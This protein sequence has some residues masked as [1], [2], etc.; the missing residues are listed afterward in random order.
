VVKRHLLAFACLIV[1]L[2][3]A[4]A[5]CG[6]SGSSSAGN[7]PTTTSASTATNGNGG[8]RAN[9][10]ALA[11][12]QSCLTAH[13]VKL[14]GF[15]GQ[16]PN[17]GT[18]PNGTPPT[19]GQPPQ[20]QGRPGRQLSAK[21][22]KAFNACRSKLPAGARGFGQG[23]PGGQ[24]NPAFAKYTACLRKHGVTFGATNNQSKFQKASA[25]CAKYR[26]AATGSGSGS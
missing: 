18:P 16:R 15:G 10:Q 12:F 2:A 9:R 1:P 3:V 24:S 8:N 20:G 13:G 25:A 7:T 14:N 26:P 19:N 17:G 5:G 4:A 11:S 6:G 23:G 22:Q 21:Q